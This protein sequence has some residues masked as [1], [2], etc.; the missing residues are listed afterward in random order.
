M[1]RRFI[2]KDNFNEE[3]IDLSR[4]TRVVAGGKRFRFRA[5]VVV[6]DGKGKVGVGVAKGLDF[7]Q[8]VNKAKADAKKNI[9]DVKMKGVTIP[10]EVEAKFGAA[11]VIIKPAVVGHGI[12]A[13]GSPR[14]VLKLA[15]IEDVTAKCLGGTKNKLTY[16]IATIEALKKIKNQK[17]K[18]K[19]AATSTTAAI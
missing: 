16:A 5:T 8:S 14:V 7:E 19:H 17:T 3:V 11:R 10:H 2:K 9:V 13:G 1:E 15:G 6:G 12:V 18:V 4:V